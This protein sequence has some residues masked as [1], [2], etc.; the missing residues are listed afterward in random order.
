MQKSSW[1]EKGMHLNPR[2]LVKLLTI[3][4]FN[5]L[6]VVFRRGFV[7][8]MMKISYRRKDDSEKKMRWRRCIYPIP[9]C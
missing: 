5:N 3:N 4:P 8:E 1:V 2:Y 6:K 9:R 7:K